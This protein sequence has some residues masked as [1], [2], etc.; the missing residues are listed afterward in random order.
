MEIIFYPRY[1]ATTVVVVEL[2]K[3][4][5]DHTYAFLE[6]RSPKFWSSKKS[7][8]SNKNC[9]VHGFNKRWIWKPENRELMDFIALVCCYLFSYQLKPYS[10]WCT[11]GSTCTRQNLLLF[12]VVK[13]LSPVGSFQ[14]RNLINTER[15]ILQPNLVS[16]P[17]EYWIYVSFWLNDCLTCKDVAYVDQ[18]IP[19]YPYN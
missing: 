11:H 19:L 10:T 16:L 6:A 15:R 1:V 3:V 13:Y 14:S 8:K 7:S 5:L 2:V 18:N 4:S 9:S 17:L 12:S